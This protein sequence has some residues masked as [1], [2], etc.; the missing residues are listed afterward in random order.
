MGYRL[1][2]RG[3]QVLILEKQAFP[4]YKP[5]GG[6]LNVR[7][8]N[9][10]DVDVSP[11]VEN[12]IYGGW[13]TY[14][15]EEPF[16]HCFDRPLAYTVSRERFDHFLLRHAIGSGCAVHEGVRVA[17]VQ[18]CADGVAVRSSGG[19]YCGRA[20]VGADGAFGVVAKSIGLMGDAFIAIAIESEVEVHPRD[21]EQ[22]KHVV[23]VDLGSM[24][25]GYG[26]VFPKADHLSIGAGAALAHARELKAYYRQFTERW[27]RSARQYHV[28]TKRGHRLPVRRKDAR[29]QRDQVLLVGDAAGLLDPL[30]GE[31]IYYAIRSAQLAADVLADYLDDPQRVGL[32]RYQALVD[33]EL[34]PEIQR[35]KAFMRLFYLCPWLLVRALRT[36][37]RTWR[38]VCEFLRG[39]KTYVEIGS[40]LGPL[41]FVLDA[42]AW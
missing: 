28:V 35:A 12:T 8:V 20:V 34:M 26:W 5:C 13:I 4:R 29:I 23:H 24:R 1:S 33:R 10:L 6:A 27:R 40:K 31:G 17:D 9:A 7:A 39:E 11:V 42:M 16:T 38:A 2:K 3:I 30:D 18:F 32:G 15:M 41:E 14:C 25:S 21:L 37:G 19:T 22:W 36:G